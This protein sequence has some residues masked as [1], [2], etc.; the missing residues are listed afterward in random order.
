MT[1]T[2]IERGS[3]GGKV[4]QTKEGRRKLLAGGRKQSHLSG[5][6]ALL[7]ETAAWWAQDCLPWMAAAAVLGLI[8][9]CFSYAWTPHS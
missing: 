8:Y 3:E 1:I 6:K 7:A 4:I 2:P 9:F 5:I